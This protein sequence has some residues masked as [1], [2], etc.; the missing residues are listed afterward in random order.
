[1]DGQ[2]LYG[3]NE[4]RLF[5]PASNAKLLTT[6]TAY[7][8]LPV[9]TMA[10][11]HQRGG[12]RRD[13]RERHA[14]RRPGHP[15]LR[16]SDSEHAPVS[17]QASGAAAASRNSAWQCSC[18]NARRNPIPWRCS[19]CWHSRWSVGGAQCGRQ[20]GGRRQLLSSTSLSELHGAGTICSGPMARRFLRFLTTRTLLQLSIV[21]DP[22]NP[23]ATVAEWSPNVE[24]Y[25]LDNTMTIAAEGRDGAPRA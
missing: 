24:Y 22:A 19:T 17:V 14:S 10:W 16:R 3:L 6:A 2:T 18:R 11:T 7:A 4:G 5:V 21:A 12:R 1:M 9:D 20:R 23:N 8:L 15:R 25:T 13:R